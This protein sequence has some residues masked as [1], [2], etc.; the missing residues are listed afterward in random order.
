METVGSG[1]GG[2]KCLDSD[3]LISILRGDKSVEKKMIE[4]D[5]EGS[6]STVSINAFEI[7]YGALHSA[8]KEKNLKEA[9][10]LL[11]SL[12]VLPLDYRVAE[13]ASEIQSNLTEAGEG[14]GLK[15]VFIAATA[16]TNRCTLVT[17]NT[18]HF[19]KI[20]ELKLEAW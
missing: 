6:A 18:R 1:D 3:F 5:A 17:K 16:I 19:S 13:K 2:V 4:I 9:K 11:N 15:D 12:E 14:I 7:L 20:G 10:R 8:K